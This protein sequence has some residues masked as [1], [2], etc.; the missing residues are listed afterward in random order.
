MT[1]KPSANIRLRL[2]LSTVVVI[3]ADSDRERERERERDS[4]ICSN[5]V[6]QYTTRHVWN[7]PVSN[8]QRGSGV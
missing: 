6:Q 7:T 4:T 5:N 2:S 8:V 3:I 1:C